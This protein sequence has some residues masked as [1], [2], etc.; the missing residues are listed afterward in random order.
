LGFV[1]TSRGAAV[2]ASAIVVA[3]G[4]PIADPLIGLGITGLILK[5]TWDSWL[6]VRGH[7]HHH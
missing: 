1:H 5:I 3:L 4:L 2:V 6:T 7:D